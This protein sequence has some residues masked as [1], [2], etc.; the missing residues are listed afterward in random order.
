MYRVMTWG[1]NGVFPGGGVPSSSANPD[2]ITDQKGGGSTWGED[3]IVYFV[4]WVGTF[5]QGRGYLTLSSP[6]VY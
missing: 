6:D 2:L 5:S 1:G 4:S 3:F